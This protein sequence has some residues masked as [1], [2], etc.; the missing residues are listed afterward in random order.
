MVKYCQQF[1]K[2][3]NMEVRSG[4]LAIAQSIVE[5][6]LEIYGQR[7]TGCSIIFTYS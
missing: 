1:R 4:C 7:E 2:L 3:V 5:N 6:I